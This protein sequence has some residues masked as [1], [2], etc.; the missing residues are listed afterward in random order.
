M[1]LRA[2][3]DAA[4]SSIA[5]DFATQPKV[6]AAIRDTLGTT[7]VHLGELASAI[8]QHERAV[9]LTNGRTGPRRPRHV[10]LD[11]TASQ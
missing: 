4:E 8:R 1:T 2:A 6:E 10:E 7:Y 5:A 3:L 9:A 11:A